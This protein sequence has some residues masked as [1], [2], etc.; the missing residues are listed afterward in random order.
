MITFRN[1]YQGSLIFE[2]IYPEEL[3]EDEESKLKTM[4]GG[5]VSYMFID[6]TIAGEV[7]SLPIKKMID[8]HDKNMKDINDLRYT[9]E[10]TSYISSFTI[11]PA[12]Q[13][14]GLSK[15]LYSYHLGRLLERGFSF[16]VGHSTSL[17][18]DALN[19][20]NGA[21]F[22]QDG[23]HKNWYGTNKTARFYEIRLSDKM[24]KVTFEYKQPDDYSCGVYAL[25]YL[26]DSHCKDFSIEHIR[27]ELKPN[28]KTGTSVWAIERFLAKNKICVYP[29][30]SSDFY[31]CGGVDHWLVRY[32]YE[33]PDEHYGV[34]TEIGSTML[35]IFDP[36][37]GQERVMTIKDFL[38]SWHSKKYGK[39]ALRIE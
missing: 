18:M 26:L 29:K 15:V 31:L 11:L 34:V 17:G 23:L 25:K 20:S 30:R 7:Y 32:V 22:T 37:I 12:F 14:K 6:G 16:V 1:E 35:H 19:R 5:E 36:W 3:R 9:T 28:R 38:S 4:D 10:N 33:A 39:W 27:R 2:S 21:Y 13:K 24:G 8:M